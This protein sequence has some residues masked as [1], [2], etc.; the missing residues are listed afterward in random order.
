MRTRI[1]P[2]KFRKV[3]FDGFSNGYYWGCYNQGGVEVGEFYYSL[4]QA[5]WVWI[6]S[7]SFPSMPRDLMKAITFFMEQLK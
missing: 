5:D 3:G 4:K 6:Q 7:G 2:Y 1:G